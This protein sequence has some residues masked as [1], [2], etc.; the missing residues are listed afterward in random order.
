MIRKRYIHTIVLTVLA[1]LTAACTADECETYSH[2]IHQPIEFGVSQSGLSVTRTVYGSSVTDNKWATTDAILIA[3]GTIAYTYY[4]SAISS[5]GDGTDYVSLIGSGT[6]IHYW[7]QAGETRTIH[8]W[9]FGNSIVPSGTT[10][11]DLPSNFTL[12][13]DGNNNDL[14]YATGS[15]THTI[16]PPATVPNAIQLD[17]YHQLAKIIVKVK[18]D[19]TTAISGVTLPSMFVS[20][21]INP[22]TNG[23]DEKVWNTTYGTVGD[24]TA[25]AESPTPD[26]TADGVVAKYSAVI[27]PANYDAGKVV[28][29]VNTNGKGD[30]NFALP[31][32][33]FSFFAGKQYIYT[34]TLKNQI[35][36]NVKVAAWTAET[37]NRELKLE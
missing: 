2:S 11:A 25:V 10:G 3:D 33:G 21:T 1:T 37:S 15:F 16:T 31:T 13:N 24:I 6:N 32:G 18:V 26:E 9:S 29:Q 12:T 22:L 36:F 4:P 28:I 14:L 30:Y 35:D 19:A 23:S 5:S 7:N 27:I 8:A 34:V 20:G 17:F